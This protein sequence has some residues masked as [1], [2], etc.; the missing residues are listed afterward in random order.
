MRVSTS[1]GPEG[2]PMLVNFRGEEVAPPIVVKGV[3]H[4]DNLEQ[5]WSEKELAAIG[6]RRVA[7][8][9]VPTSPQPPSN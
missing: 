5:A 1:N 6:L 4:P 2:F 9:A 7:E 3:R 8:P